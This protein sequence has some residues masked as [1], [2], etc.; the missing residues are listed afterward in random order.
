[1]P[2]LHLYSLELVSCTLYVCYFVHLVD[3]YDYDFD[4]FAGCFGD[5][6]FVD[7]ILAQIV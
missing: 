6:Y 4:Y 7:D 1:M 5:S 2:L 3:T